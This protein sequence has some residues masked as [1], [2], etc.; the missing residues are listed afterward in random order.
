MPVKLEHSVFF[1]HT[2]FRSYCQ[3]CSLPSSFRSRTFFSL[4]LKNVFQGG[5]E[6]ERE[7]EGE[8]EK[9]ERNLGREKKGKE[10]ERER[11]RVGVDDDE[12]RVMILIVSEG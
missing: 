2:F 4:I 11:E 3:K 1:K 5:R 9:R 6:R 10:I 12:I 8:R 7:V